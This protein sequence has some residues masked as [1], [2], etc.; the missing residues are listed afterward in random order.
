MNN[1]ATHQIYKEHQN[2]LMLCD[3]I[4]KFVCHIDDEDG[5]FNFQQAIE[6][7]RHLLI[8][9]HIPREKQLTRHFL[10][11]GNIPVAASCSD[12]RHADS[13][14]TLNHLDELI[15]SA[16]NGSLVRKKDIEEEA[17]HTVENIHQL[18]DMEERRCLPFIIEASDMEP[19]GTAGGSDEIDIGDRKPT[20]VAPH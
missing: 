14:S 17:R 9:I 16:M 19:L 20:T 10:A 4:E 6:N 2:A 11:G 8:N 7:L 3:D 18:I 5:Y 12:D 13:I 1:Q 15:N